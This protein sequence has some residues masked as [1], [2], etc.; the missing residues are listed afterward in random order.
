MNAP[1]P[2]F[3]DIASRLRGLRDALGLSL[4]EMAAKLGVPAEVAQKYETGRTEIPVSYLIGVARLGQVDLNVLISGGEAH[5]HAYSLIRKGAG[6]NVERR[7]TYDYRDLAYR[8][9]GRR[10]EPLLVTVPALPPEGLSFNEHA[11]QEFIHMIEGRLEVHL[12]KK[13]EILEPGDSLY[14]A[15]RTPHA[16]RGLDGAP[17]V[18]LDV[19]VS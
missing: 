4:A 12:D 15:S 2:Y 3:L 10:M 6:L 14:F 17:A 5:L 9:S 19:I 16:L 7:K 13:V 1:D 8:F 11:G 18:F